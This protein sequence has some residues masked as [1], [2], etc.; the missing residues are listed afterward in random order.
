MASG[1]AHAHEVAVMSGGKFTPVSVDPEKAQMTAQREFQRSEVATLYGLQKDLTPP[2]AADFPR[3]V[4]MPYLRR[5][6]GR[7]S[8]LL[9]RGTFAEFR[10]AGILRSDLSTRYGAFAVALQNGFASVNEVRALDN[11]PS[12]GPDGD[13]YARLAPGVGTPNAHPTGVP[14]T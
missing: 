8:L 1:V 5:I 14:T 10:T 3:W 6:E 11:M 4:L 7:F 9:P 2:V 12:I 13:V